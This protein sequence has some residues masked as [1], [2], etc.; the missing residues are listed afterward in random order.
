MES[1]KADRLLESDQFYAFH[2]D[3]RGSKRLD[4]AAGRVRFT[5]TEGIKVFEIALA[6]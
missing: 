1:I 6:N 4:F 2:N 3:E 5:I